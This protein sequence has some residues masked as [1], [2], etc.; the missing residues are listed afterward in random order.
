MVLGDEI[1]DLSDP[2]VDARLHRGAELPS[3]LRKDQQGLG[4]LE[5]AVGQRLGLAGELVNLVGLPR[6]GDEHAHG[7]HDAVVERRGGEHA[8]WGRGDVHGHE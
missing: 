5:L 1:L 2:R 8:E 3:D 6:G 7:A 4:V